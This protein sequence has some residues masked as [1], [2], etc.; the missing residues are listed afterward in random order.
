MVILLIMYLALIIYII[1][2]IF[3][4][5]VFSC[6]HPTHIHTYLFFANFLS[7]SYQFCCLMLWT[8]GTILSYSLVGLSVNFCMITT[9][10]IF[11]K[12]WLSS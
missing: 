9:L 10:H 2:S 8:I 7:S 5:I 3:L 6:C 11:A 4:D 1:C 12:L